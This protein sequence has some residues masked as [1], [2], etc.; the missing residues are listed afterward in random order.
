MFH[1]KGLHASGLC[2]TSDSRVGLPV[3][4]VKV[5]CVYFQSFLKYGSAAQ[6]NSH[7]GKATAQQ[8][9]PLQIEVK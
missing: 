3:S 2:F 8:T 4:V 1:L 6:Q 9:T 7:A 5:S